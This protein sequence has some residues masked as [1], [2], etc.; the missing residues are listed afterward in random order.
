MSRITVKKIKVEHAQFYVD[1]CPFQAITA[2]SEGYLSI[3]DQCRICKLCLK[4][5]PD[6]FS[7]EEDIPVNTF[8]Q[9]KTKDIAVFLEWQHEKIH[10]VSWELLCKAR[11]M[12]EPF[13][14]KVIGILVGT[15]L[16]K[17]REEFS[18][19]PLDEVVI[20]DSPVLKYF[21]IEPYTAAIIDFIEE[22]HPNVLLIGATPLGRSLAPR[23]AIAS[24]T[25]LTADCTGLELRGDGTLIQTR[26]AFGGNIMAQIKTPNGRPQMATVRPHVMN[27]KRVANCSSPKTT[28]RSLENASQYSKIRVLESRM[29]PPAQDLGEADVVIAVGRGIK[30][31]EDLR[32]IQDLA[33]SLSAVVAFSRPLIEA[34]WADSR[35][36]I[37]LSGRSI[38]PKLLVTVGISGAVQFSAGIQGADYI[39]AINSDPDA[40]IFNVA[41]LGFVG[42]C[43]EIIPQVSSLLKSLRKKE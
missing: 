36:Q 14:Q 21:R 22:Y 38:Q 24:K 27:S 7:F 18:E 11:E 39:V 40:P 10:P 3:N 5:G 34:G 35:F 26:P 8:H 41:D 20:Y 17:H 2:D 37:G 23:V 28:Y 25:G 33:Q 19:Y 9:T 30:R 6:L 13:Q 29:K 32:M 4:F 1:S 16:E 42:D 12:G 31:P 43:Y 15:S